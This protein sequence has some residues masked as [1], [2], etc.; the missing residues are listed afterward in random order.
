MV[1]QTESLGLPPALQKYVDTFAMVPDPKLRYQQLLFF[2]RQLPTMDP[3]LKVDENRVHG[4]TSVVHVKVSLDN[5]GKVRLQG[6]SDS[7]LTKGLLSL[8]IN[9][10]DGATPI[11]V[12][13]VDPRFISVSGLSVSLT[14]SRNNGF[15]NML[16]KIKK[17]VSNLLGGE[18]QSSQTDK[19][20]PIAT[21]GSDRP[22][23]SAIMRKL[24]A[25]K[26][27]ELHVR[28][29]SAQ[30]AGHAG[31]KGL[32]GESHFAV[33]VVSEAFNSLNQVQRHRM[34]YALLGDEMSAGYIHA[35]QIIA[36]TPEEAEG[37]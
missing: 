34:I 13:A 30:H 4:C 24:Q 12:Q 22:V 19:E 18:E 7:Q 35:L 20:E 8:L 6:D 16:A 36:K 9:G 14:P 25:L 2:A 33:S 23:Y 11:E 27:R 29:D 37:I 17:D 10:L 26:P 15:V 28:D 3:S 5:E 31:S 21:I 1:A 32:S